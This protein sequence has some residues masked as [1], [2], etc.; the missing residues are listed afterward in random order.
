MTVC[1]DLRNCI[2]MIHGCILFFIC[3]LYKT[4]V[5][6]SAVHSDPNA[7]RWIKADGVDVL[8]GLCESTKGQWSGDV[9]LNNGQLQL[10]YKQLQDQLQWI[11]LIGLNERRHT[12]TITSDLKVATNY[13][14]TDLEFTHSGMK[15]YN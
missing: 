10:L 2:I 7:W 12:E 1:Y 6:E 8:K 14:V 13:L 11:K 5:L 4:S 3:V 15:M 9:D